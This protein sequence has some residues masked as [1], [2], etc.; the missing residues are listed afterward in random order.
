MK[1]EFPSLKDMKKHDEALLRN[2][3]YNEKKVS[4]ICEKDMY[5]FNASQVDFEI[6]GY[7]VCRIYLGRG[8]KI[9]LKVKDH[10]IL[11]IDNYDSEVEITKDITAQCTIWDKR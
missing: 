10:A 8:T 1:N 7:D 6:S 11:Y 5:V 3:V 2:G 4:I 9:N